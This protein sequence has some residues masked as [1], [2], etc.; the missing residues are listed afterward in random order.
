MPNQ[1]VLTE[2][3]QE[4]IAVGASIAAGCQPCTTYHFR[5]AR[6]AGADDEEIHQAVSNALRVRHSATRVMARIGG[7]HLGEVPTSETACCEDGTLISELISVSAAFAV[8]CTTNLETHLAAARQQG[9]TDS[10]ILTALKIACAVKGT[11][12]KKVEAAA[13]KA[14]GVTEDQSD[15]CGCDD[16]SQSSSASAG[17]SCGETERA[18]PTFRAK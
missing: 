18:V 9:A 10:Q 3:E 14:L 8:N 17:C 13:A 11:A 12:G 16:T 7:S 2:K 4:L 15:D 6:I 5:A 1:S